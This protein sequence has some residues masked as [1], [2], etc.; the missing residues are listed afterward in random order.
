MSKLNTILMLKDVRLSYPSLFERATFDG[1][2][3][4]Y[5][6]S[7]LIEDGDAQIGEI[8][9][10]FKSMM[11]ESNLKIPAQKLCL[12]ESQGDD[13]YLVF[14]ASNNRKPIVIDRD[15][16]PLTADDGRIYAGCYV[17]AKV[18]CWL[19]NNRFGKRINA[20]LLAVQFVRDG[21]RFAGMSSDMLMDGFTEIDPAF[22]D[23]PWDDE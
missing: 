20:N 8:R 16:S 1:V 5:E 2:E 7:F 11:Q 23:M 15:L 12:T 21:E 9:K 3:G 19:Q 10:L 6:A 22:E 14:K 4:K 17:N 13:E 18:N